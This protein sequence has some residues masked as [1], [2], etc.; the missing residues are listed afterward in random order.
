[1]RKDSGGNKSVTV[2]FPTELEFSRRRFFFSGLFLEKYAI[3][4]VA[5]T[6]RGVTF[7]CLYH[8]AGRKSPFM[9]QTPSLL[10][11]LFPLVGCAPGSARCCPL[12]GRHLGK[13]RCH[14]VGTVPRD[15]TLIV[16][17]LSHGES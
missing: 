10:Y 7:S 17:K 15:D 14:L 11:N 5:K 12:I 1:M 4:Y 13:I 16:R 8:Q 3:L 9:R 6:D 2:I